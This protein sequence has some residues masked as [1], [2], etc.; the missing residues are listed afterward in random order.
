ML[1]NITHSKQVLLNS[2]IDK[3][4]DFLTTLEIK[5]IWTMQLFEIHVTIT[6]YLLIKRAI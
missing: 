3:P 5:T 6:Y 1:T 2:H 4:I